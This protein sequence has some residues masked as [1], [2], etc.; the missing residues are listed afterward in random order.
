MP[1]APVMEAIIRMMHSVLGR[2]TETEKEGQREAER[3]RERERI[4]LEYFQKYVLAL[5]FLDVVL[6]SLF[7]L[8]FCS[9][10]FLLCNK[11]TP[12]LSGLNHHCF[13]TFHDFVA[14][15]LGRAWLGNPFIPC[16]I[17]RGHCTW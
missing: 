10:C 5:I 4:L 7:L 1:L 16:V 14:R 9:S 3:E 17:D 15:S 12:I 13:I 11:L 6:F 2:D 8:S